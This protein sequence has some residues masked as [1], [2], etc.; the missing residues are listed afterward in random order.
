MALC[1]P[2]MVTRGVSRGGRNEVFAGSAVIRKVPVPRVALRS[3]G[4]L[5]ISSTSGGRQS[6][7]TASA[8]M[9][10]RSISSTGC[11]AAS[12]PSPS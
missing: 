11:E 2:G 3:A 4:V 9:A 6:T 7:L 8:A 10:S 1:G 12:W 5:R